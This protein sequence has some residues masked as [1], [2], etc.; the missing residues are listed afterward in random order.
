METSFFIKIK[1]ET[2]AQVVVAIPI[3]YE[4]IY[5]FI[6]SSGIMIG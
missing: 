2:N 3:M 6:E 5:A 4:I 1:R